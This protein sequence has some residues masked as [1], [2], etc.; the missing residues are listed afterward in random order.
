MLHEFA[1]ERRNLHGHFS[2]ELAPVLTI[3]PGDSVRIWVPNSGWRLDSGEQFGP[4]DERLDGGHALAGRIEVRR[5]TQVVNE[6]S[7]VHAVLRD[8]ALR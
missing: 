2:R 4:L 5:A 1:L 3:E 8:D 6:R 7:G